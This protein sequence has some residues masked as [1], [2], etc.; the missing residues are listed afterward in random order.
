MAKSKKRIRA[1]KVEAFRAQNLGL[2]QSKTFLI[3]GAKKIFTKL[4]QAFIEAPILNHFDLEHYIQIETDKFDY[5]IGKI[6]S[7][8]TLD[9]LGW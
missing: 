3:S 1:K 5:T 2:S 6:F 4:K 8:L 9:N 7:Q